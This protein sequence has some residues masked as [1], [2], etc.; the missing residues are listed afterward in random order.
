MQRK[1]KNFLL[2]TLDN[3]RYDF[4]A[5]PDNKW[6]KTP[7]FREFA[8]ES[9]RFSNHYDQIP[10]TP[11]AH[12]SLLYGVD[13]I[14]D[15]KVKWT[16]KYF[17]GQSIPRFFRKKGYKTGAIVSAL[18][19]RRD[20]SP[21]V[22]GEFD[23]YDDFFEM[24]I[25]KSKAKE[26]LIKSSKS[27]YKKFKYL[28][29]YFLKKNHYKD[30]FPALPVQTGEVT[31]NKGIQFIDSQK[32]QPWFLWMHIFDAHVASPLEKYMKEKY[33]KS[34][35]NTHGHFAPEEYMFMYDKDD[36]EKRNYVVKHITQDAAKFDKINKYSGCVTYVD[37]L[38]GK[39][40][41]YLKEN[42]LYDNTVIIAMADHGTPLGKYG[43][44]TKGTNVLDFT[45]KVPF[46][47]KL[48]GKTKTLKPI[49]H[50][51]DVL[52]IIKQVYT[53]G[54][55]D[56]KDLHQKKSIFFESAQ[57]F[58]KKGDKKMY[59]MRG[60]NF[61]FLLELTKGDKGIDKY[62][63]HY[64]DMDK[65]PYEDSNIFPALSEQRKKKL[66]DTLKK[67]FNNLD[68]HRDLIQDFKDSAND[69]K[70][71]KRLEALGYM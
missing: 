20:M 49:T 57:G 58:A 36:E 23:V 68:S 45:V 4:F 59:G 51:G 53:H 41:S 9:Y 13:L 64:F 33:N 10:F 39:I 67:R 52:D 8:K 26:F 44:P 30:I 12:F 63:Y 1:K 29:M 61:K 28:L 6:I 69:E 40:V 11:P 35:V 48:N 55:I 3:V 60:P 37:H 62:D 31:V 17:L 65:D 21:Y 54:D 71:R 32:D 19:L 27:K 22:Q 14:Q 70:I 7:N 47:M 34:Y 24:N 16:S 25:K 46:F 50:H 5:H 43:H 38:F 2:I 66:I 42:D 18:G 56:E 15:S